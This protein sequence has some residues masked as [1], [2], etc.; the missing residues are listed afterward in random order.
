MNSCNGALIKII[1]RKYK[2]LDEIEEGGIMYLKIEFDKMFN[3]SNV[4]IT[5][6]HEFIK[7]VSNDRIYNIPNEIVWI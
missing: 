2:N 3:M 7:K 4:V 5:S 6:L 1:D